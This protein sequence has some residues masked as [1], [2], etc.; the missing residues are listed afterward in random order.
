MSIPPYRLFCV[1]FPDGYRKPQ[2]Y[3]LLPHKFFFLRSRYS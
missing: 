3:F 1:K 2:K